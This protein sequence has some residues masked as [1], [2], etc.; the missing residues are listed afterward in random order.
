L[1]NGNFKLKKKCKVQK[2]NINIFN[3]N[4]SLL[5]LSKVSKLIDIHRYL[6]CAQRD[7]GRVRQE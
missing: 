6:K 1:L 5:I 3:D 7:L 4:K 2:K